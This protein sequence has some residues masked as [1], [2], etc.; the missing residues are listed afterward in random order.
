M[1][2]INFPIVGIGASAGGLAAFESFFSGMPNDK[3]PGMA[4][5]LV[6]HLD[7]NHKS[8]LTE[9]ISRFTKMKVFEVEDGM[10]VSINCT[11]IIPPNRDMKLFN[12]KLELLD[13]ELPHGKRLPIDFFFQSLAM[14]QHERAICIVLS[15]SG[16]D[17]SQGLRSIKA[18]G[19]LAIAQ[20]LNTCEYDSMPKSA[21]STGLVDWEL[22]PPEMPSRLIA[23]ASHEIINKIT[24][25]NPPS[26]SELNKAAMSE[27]FSI[28]QKHTNHDFSH[29]KLNTMQRR[30][31]RR[32]AVH[33]NNDLD[34]YLNFLKSNLLEIEALFQDLLIGVTS[35]FRDSD[36]FKLLEEQV[37]PKIF[38]G[39][40]IGSTIRLWS[41]G[42]STGEEAYS[43]AILLR[44]HIEK[45]NKNFKIQIFATDINSLAISKARSGI[46]PVSISLD[47]TPERLAKYFKLE[48][49][50]SSYRII[51][52][53]R[54]ML[55]FSEQDVVRDPPFSRIDLICCRNLMIYLSA[56]VQKRLIRL[57]HFSLNPKGFLFL[58]TSETLGEYNYLFDTL[59]RQ[60]KLYRRKEE[61]HGLQIASMRRIFRPNLLKDTQQNIMPAKIQPPE[62]LPL[63]ELTEQALLKQIAPSS[64]LVNSQG[65]ILYLHGRTGMYLEPNV[66]EVG[67]YNI[68]KMARQ[69]LKEELASA[70]YK[71]SLTKEII[72]VPNLLVKTNGDF[73]AVNLT[74]L[75][76]P[77][78]IGNLDEL[79][80]LVILEDTIALNKIDKNQTKEIINPSSFETDTRILQLTKEIKSK[81]NFL[82]AANEEL[83]TTNEELKSSNEEMQSINEELQST[84]EELETAKEEMQ[85][86]NEELSTVN[87][88]LQS[89]VHELSRTNND[90]NNLLSGT[91]IAT[92][93]VD[94]K[95]C[96]LRFTPTA[97]KII[98]LIQG[99]IGRP[100]AH[101]VSNFT[102]YN[103]L[104]EDTQSVH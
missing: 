64:A 68:L 47:I 12:G 94:F 66:G 102:N 33:Q 96:I 32:M 86:V 88:E 104:L 57:F 53:V 50:G 23:Y 5:V 62:K 82:Q 80:Y 7:P 29:Y 49:D 2:S 60:L 8:L 11:Y 18:E 31:D 75:Y 101:I 73:S 97:T 10:T 74:V 1:S 40:E 89:K 37:I 85:S 36:A 35:F 70:L 99:D 87:A 76:V 65:D 14:D 98:N 44:E 95:L 15:G 41:L 59:D 30:I 3:D 56:E 83:E 43:L 27:I 52:S 48:A 21:I 77:T 45:I 13:P 16:S 100:V 42:C 38:E 84:N 71:C 91:G 20:S 93:F 46:Y 39:K 24:Q 28:L 34:S 9:I 79:L 61:I 58:G 17:G 78:D 54:D 103:Q 63:R 55:I 26:E 72:R 67:I 81:E 25:G 92:V 4:F 22:P 51:K 90:M 19:G 69:G 6:Q